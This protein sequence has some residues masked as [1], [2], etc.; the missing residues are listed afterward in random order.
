MLLP[1]CREDAARQIAER[2]RA[3][4]EHAHRA[5][6]DPESRWITISI[7]ITLS[8]TGDTPETL[9]E[10]ADRALQEAK[11]GGRNRWAWQQPTEAD[12]SAP[13]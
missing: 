11:R 4:V 10:R 1:H 2:L 3:A 6:P 7:G 9:D 8:A 5:H 13:V 12:S